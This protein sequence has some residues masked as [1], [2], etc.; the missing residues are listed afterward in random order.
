MIPWLDALK[1][2]TG[3]QHQAIVQM[4][5]HNLHTDRQT[6]GREAGRHRGGRL[7]GKIEREAERQPVI[8]AHHAAIN[9]FR[10]LHVQRK[11]RHR[12]RR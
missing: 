2:G 5:T 1:S 7:T 12:Q 10:A 6:T 11:R 3:R 9:D 8:A 4:T